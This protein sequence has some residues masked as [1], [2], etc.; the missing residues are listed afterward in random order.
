MTR[1]GFGRKKFDKLT[2]DFYTRGAYITEIY[3]HSV[4][5]INIQVIVL[6]IH[7]IISLLIIC[8]S[9]SNTYTSGR[10]CW[11]TMLLHVSF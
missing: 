9:F 8:N 6:L 1:V 2:Y 3:V 11:N 7:K 4:T 5:I 10:N